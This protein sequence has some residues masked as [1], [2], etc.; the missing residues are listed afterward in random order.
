MRALSRPGAQMNL[1]HSAR[2]IIAARVWGAKDFLFFFYTPG[3]RYDT[4]HP[5]KY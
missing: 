1:F 5:Q 4:E 2:I 3:E